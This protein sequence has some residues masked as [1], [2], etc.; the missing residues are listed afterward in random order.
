MLSITNG[1]SLKEQDQ[2][3]RESIVQQGEKAETEVTVDDADEE[4]DGRWWETSVQKE[5]KIEE[6]VSV[7]HADDENKVKK[8]QLSVE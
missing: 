8:E 3:G 2:K 6:E 1:T 4:Q 7:D 5:E